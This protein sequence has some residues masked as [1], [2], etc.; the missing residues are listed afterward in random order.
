[1]DMPGNHDLRLFVR[2][3]MFDRCSSRSEHRWLP[4]HVRGQRVDS[5]MT[6]PSELCALAPRTAIREWDNDQHLG[7]RGVAPLPRPRQCR[8][9]AC[10][11]ASYPPPDQSS[12]RSFV[13]LLIPRPSFNSPS[14][15]VGRAGNSGCA[16][17]DRNGLPTR[18]TGTRSLICGESRKQ[19]HSDVQFF[20]RRSWANRIRR[21]NSAV[22]PPNGTARIQIQ[23][24]LQIS[25][26]L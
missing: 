17:G 2:A 12:V 11:C 10:A 3:H 24:E 13:A 7:K 21:T 6:F 1:M 20:L 9:A 23:S 8:A 16:S 19:P 4:C 26:S 25:Y 22:A 18:E 15:L 14:I 5:G